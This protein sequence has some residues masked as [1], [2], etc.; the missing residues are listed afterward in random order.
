[1]ACLLCVQHSDWYSASVP[2]II[3]VKSY[4]IGPRYNGTPLYYDKTWPH[5]T[6]WFN[7]CRA[8]LFFENRKVYFFK[9]ANTDENGIGGW[10]QSSQDKMILPFVYSQCCCRLGDARRQVISSHIVDLVLSEF[11]Q[12]KFFKKIF[13]HRSVLFNFKK[14]P[15]VSA[16]SKITLSVICKSYN[17]K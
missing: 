12:E 9:F 10:T 8:E 5:C 3:Y 13:R 16:A 4:N 15:L 11:Q 6:K 1:M 2:V 7:L 17:E 14:K